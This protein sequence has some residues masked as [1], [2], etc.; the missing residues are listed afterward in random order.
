MLVP[1][2]LRFSTLVL[3]AGLYACGRAGTASGWGTP[4]VLRIGIVS[5]P[6]SLNPLFVTSQAAVDMG[7]LYTETLVGS[8]PRNE[9]VPLVAQQI[10]T[11]Q[12]GGISTDT[13]TIT[14]HLRR[15]ER[16]ADGT[17]LTSAE[18]CGDP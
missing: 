10:P 1:R 8:S 17:A 9:L 12:N 11:R 3:L 6:S 15:D 7:Q 4:N 5:D 13:R 2:I 16:F 18:R 14:Y